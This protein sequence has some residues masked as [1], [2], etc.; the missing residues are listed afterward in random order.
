MAL[1][2]ARYEYRLALSHVDR[3]VETA[4]TVI[5]ARHPSETAE[6]LTVRVLAFCLL[7]RE[8]IGFGPGLA[9]GEASDLEAHDLTGRVTLWVECGATDAD[10]LR[11]VVQHH[12]GAEVHVVF[13]GERRREELLA[14]LAAAPRA[15][16]G[17]ERVTL[18]TLDPALV[19]AAAENEE[20]RQ[21]WVVTIVG[22]HV[23][24]EI[25][26]RQLDG[27]VERASLSPPA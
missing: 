26:G 23:Y 5:A 12:P 25:D 4:E 19:R 15:I 14:Q 10:K 3:G 22:D 21:R 13:A 2:S 7:H 1:P 17:A 6:H 18:W 20:R 24:L 11:R 8:G 9:D 27:P 16:R